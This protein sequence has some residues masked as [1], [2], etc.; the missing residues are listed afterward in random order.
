MEC[1]KELLTVILAA[2]FGYTGLQAQNSLY[3]IE[4]SGNQ[5][6]IAFSDIQK[7]TFSAGNLSVYKTDGNADSYDLI[8]V[9]CIRFKDYTTDVV[10]AAGK[11]RSSAILYPNPVN[12]QLQISYESLGTGNVE[13]TIMD[14]LGKALIRQNL[15]CQRGM[16]HAIISL[17]LL[18]RGLYVCLIQEGNKAEISKFIKNE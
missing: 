1:K 18:S 3:V 10:P 15:I 11:E 9:R 8:S 7:L 6:S 4:K 16:N 5:A 14:L 13:V 17:E 2:V 12:G